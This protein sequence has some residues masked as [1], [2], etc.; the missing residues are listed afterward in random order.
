MKDYWNERWKREDIG[1]HQNEI[2]PY[3]RR[4]WQELHLARG[5]EV[6]V[7]LCGKSRD[8]LWLRNQG[9]SVLGVELSPIAVCAFF[10]ENGYT[11]RLI[12][13]KSDQLDP[14]NRWKA[15][16]IRILCG[17]FFDLSKDDL[18]KT[19]AVY[20]RASLVALPPDIRALY[21]FHLLSI[22][23]P[24]T[25]ILLITFDYPQREMP[26]PPFA[27]STEEVE[28]LY[29]GRAEIRLLA[30]LDVLEQNPRFRE[31]GLSRLHESIFLLSSR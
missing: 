29:R 12:R 19:S 20:D 13:E 7:P 30:Q 22:L 1:F 26:G 23:P 28:A 16:G 10:E 25:Q 15:D 18:A 2:N 17:D 5:S 11:R 27:V 4:Y 21:T 24:G 6:F 31:R 3:L 8:M 14:F 9:Y